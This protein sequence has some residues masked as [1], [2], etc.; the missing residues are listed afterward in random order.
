MDVEQVSKAQESLG[1]LSME[2][3][4]DKLLNS[5]VENDED[6]ISNGRMVSEALNQGFSSFVPD[7]MFENLVKNYSMAQNLYGKKMVR[8]VS[9]F[10]PDYV[11]KNIKIPE[12]QRALKKE[13]EKRIDQLK[14]ENLL[15]KD[16]SINE[17]G[18]QLASLIM[19]TEELD[20]IIPKGTMGQKV[21]KSRYIYGE[22]E[23]YENYRKGKRFADIALRRSAK[24]AIRRM[25]DTITEHD[26]VVFERKSKGN[27]QMIYALDSSGSMKGKKIETAKKAGIALA[28][29]A[30]SAKDK[31]GLIVFGT[32]VKEKIRPTLDFGLLLKRIAGV[33]ASKETNI[34]ATLQ[35]ALIMFDSSQATKHL[36]LL[37]D[38]MPTIGKEPENEALQA[39]A[40]LANIGITVSIIGIDLDK[41][42]EDLAKKMAEIGKGSLYVAKSLCD[43]DKIILEDYYSIA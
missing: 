27:V 14:D 25:H 20:K 17:R 21:H 2:N 3:Y 16:G 39:A 22:K 19:Y 5:V 37:T 31:V 4:E 18:L 24:R 34:T 36:L 38:A 43:L 1:A 8:L 12:F 13:I 15:D 42:G 6:T 35:A 30:I 7:T 26:I 28:Y 29:K 40:V 32:E 11:E 10:S 41:E 9:G 33:T 23:D